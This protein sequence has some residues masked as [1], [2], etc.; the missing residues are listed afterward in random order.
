MFFCAALRCATLRC[1]A[2]RLFCNA[3]FLARFARYAAFCIA[4]FLARCMFSGHS[5]RPLCLPSDFSA[6]AFRLVYRGLYERQSETVRKL[7]HKY[8]HIAVRLCFQTRVCACTYLRGEFL[9]DRLFC[10][11]LAPLLPAKTTE[12]CAKWCPCPKSLSGYP[13]L[14]PTE[15]FMKGTAVDCS[16]L[17]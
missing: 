5:A 15:S 3:R 17:H 2:L 8:C 16:R 10:R 1:A 9:A 14:L 13:H 6:I 11:L 12:T 4:R 7:D